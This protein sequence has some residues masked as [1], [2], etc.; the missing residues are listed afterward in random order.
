[1]FDVKEGSTP[2]K[3]N[4]EPADDDG[5][6]P[7]KKRGKDELIKEQKEKE[8][9]H[10]EHVSYD[11]VHC[12]IA[13]QFLSYGADISF[14]D[15]SGMSSLDIAQNCPSL[16]DLLTK[17]IE[18]DTIS[19]LIPWTSVSDKCKGILTKVARRQECKM[20]D[21][22]WNYRDQIAVGSFGLIFAGINEKD[23]REVAVKRIEK[24]R[25]KRPEDRREIKNLIALADCEQVVR[26]ISV[27]EGGDFSYIVLN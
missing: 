7:A 9:E 14:R 4:D 6:P 24:L 2:K 20:V 18:I 15:S 25:L 8:E 23:G 26:Y 19:I 13:K 12:K 10:L 21:Q 16:H 11:S 3:A 17:Q 1:M 22:I 5:R 27:F